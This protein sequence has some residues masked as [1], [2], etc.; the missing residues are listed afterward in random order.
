MPNFIELRHSKVEGGNAV[1]TFIANDGG[2]HVILVDRGCA[3]V[4]AMALIAA[5]GGIET[6]PLLLV[7]VEPM[8]GPTGR[9]ALRLKYHN[10]VEF[11]LQV[12]PEAL[13]MLKRAIDILEASLPKRAH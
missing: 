3:A 9:R 6:Q 2:E 11:D 13:S 8:A 10:N 5:A 1:L 4:T 12:S 7:D